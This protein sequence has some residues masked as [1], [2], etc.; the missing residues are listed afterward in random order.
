MSRYGTQLK[1]AIR[2]SSLRTVVFGVVAVA[3]LLIAIAFAVLTLDIAALNGDAMTARRSGQVLQVANA[4][5]ASVIDLETGLRGYA[6]TGERGFLQP[7]FKGRAALASQLTN[8]VALS[9]EDPDQQLRARRIV[10]AIVSYERSYGARLA[11]SDVPLTNAEQRAVTLE[12]RRLLDPIRDRYAIFERAEQLRSNENSA[13]AA[14]SRR[15]VLVAAA[16]CFIAV[17]LLLLA[18]TAYLARSCPDAD[19]PRCPGCGTSGEAIWTP[20]FLRG[21][22]VR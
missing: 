12:G 9:G 16:G 8:L 3:L 15:A 20:Q 5:E 14:S 6:L 13:A 2:R 10:V 7:Y 22:L 1:D 4:S 17:A 19:A 18:L 11:A 21:D